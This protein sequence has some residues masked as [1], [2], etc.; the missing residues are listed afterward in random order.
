MGS[1]LLVQLGLELTNLGDIVD[2]H[3][4]TKNPKVKPEGSGWLAIF[5]KTYPEILYRVEGWR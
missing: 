1:S 2:S 4:S 3:E 5:G